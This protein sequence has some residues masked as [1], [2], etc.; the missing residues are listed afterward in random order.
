MFFIDNDE[1]PY[2]EEM[3]LFEKTDYNKFK[4]SKIKCDL[5]NPA[6]ALADNSEREN[7]LRLTVM[8]NSTSNSTL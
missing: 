4:L 5:S 2:N 1:N 3:I 7:H 6:N 8:N